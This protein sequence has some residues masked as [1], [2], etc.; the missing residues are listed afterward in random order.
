[1]IFAS[2]P[3]TGFRALLAA[4]TLGVGVVALA[5]P[6]MA[7]G[8]MGGMGMGGFHGGMGMGGFHGGMGGFGGFHPPVFIHQGF[9]SG[10]SPGFHPGFAG[11]PFMGN[12]AVF[13]NRPF[14]FHHHPFNDNALAFGLV[15]GTVLGGLAYDYPYYDYPYYGATYGGDC[16]VIHRRVVNPWGRIV[17]R[18]AVVCS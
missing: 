6:T 2:Q 10:F 15:G 9:H 11:R 5:A 13:V 4:I 12:R 7:R 8:G 18:R 17:L 3:G 14:F 16:F 1:M